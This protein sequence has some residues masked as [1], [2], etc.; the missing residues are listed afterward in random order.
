MTK[1]PSSKKALHGNV[2]FMINTVKCALL[3]A[4]FSCMY[5]E[6]CHYTNILK[7]PGCNWIMAMTYRGKELL[8]VFYM[9]RRTKHQ[10]WKMFLWT[11]LNVGLC[12]MVRHTEFLQTSSCGSKLQ[13]NPLSFSAAVA[14]LK[15]LSV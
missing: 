10:L 6:N 11:I 13:R 4:R 5:S 12:I 7:G 14:V 15:S 3:N 9:N 2:I 1:Y 8:E